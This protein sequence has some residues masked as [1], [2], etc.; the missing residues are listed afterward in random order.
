VREEAAM[1]EAEWLECSDPQAMLDFLW[2]KSGKRKLR[3]FACACC[4]QVWQYMR[5]PACR[6]AVEVSEFYAD[7]KVRAAKLRL[8][9]REAEEEASSRAWEASIRMWLSQ[10]AAKDAANAAV[11]CAAK[12]VDPIAVAAATRACITSTP[13]SPKDQCGLLRDLFGHLLLRPSAPLPASVLAWSDG[14]VRRIAQGIYEERAFD[15]LP[16]LHDALL[17]P[18]CDDEAILAHCRGPGPHVRGCWV[19]DLILGKS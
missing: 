14:T 9:K 1:T 10:Y 8:A 15:R 6:R 19:V 17:D 7:R 13:D 16:I 5:D 4:R 11:L 12:N 18:G 2:R 3:L